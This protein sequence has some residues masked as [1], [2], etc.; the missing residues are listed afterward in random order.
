MGANMAITMKSAKISEST[1]A[2]TENYNY[3]GGDINYP[4][5]P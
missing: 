4:V 3:N 1:S 5:T 2:E